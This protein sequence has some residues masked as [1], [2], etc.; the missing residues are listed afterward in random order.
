MHGMGRGR[1]DLPG[2]TARQR[3]VLELLARGHTNVEIAEALGISANGAKWHVGELLTKFGV[4]SREDLAER[5][6]RERGFRGRAGRWFGTLG[7]SKAVGVGAATIALGSAGMA[8]GIR[9]FVPAGDS[10]ELAAPVPPPTSLA[11]ASITIPP[12]FISPATTAPDAA[13]WRNPGRLF[14]APLGPRNSAVVAIQP[15]DTLTNL[16][17]GPQAYVAHDTASVPWKVRAD[18]SSDRG[19]YLTRVLGD[20]VLYVTLEDL[21][22]DHIVPPFSRSP[23]NT[24]PAPGAVVTLQVQDS[25][26]TPFASLLDAEG[27]LFISAAPLRDLAF[28]EVNGREIKFASPKQLGSFHPA[29]SGRPLGAWE[30]PWWFNNCE[31]N[32]CHVSMRVSDLLAPVSG[33][34]KCDAPDRFTITTP[35]LVIEIATIDTGIVRATLPCDRTAVSAGDV[36][37]TYFAHYLISARTPAGRALSV[38]A[39]EAGALLTGE[40]SVSNDCPCIQLN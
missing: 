21:A 9:L 1:Q 37:V 10:M 32:L 25:F 5:W 11:V 8:V 18:V 6:R 23:G 19:L 3:E 24:A 34:F 29:G 22:D 16:V 38:A 28:N 12:G 7:V 39:T 30:A 4:N 20:D 17:A 13:E 40:A 14:V 33:A 26:G 36:L 31:A 27:T 15:G 2:L 35:N